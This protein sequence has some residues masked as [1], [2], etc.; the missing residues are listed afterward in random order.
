MELGLKT[1]S[2]MATPLCMFCYLRPKNASLIHGRLGHQV[3][4]TSDSI[5]YMSR[6]ETFFLSCSALVIEIR[7]PRRKPEELP[8]Y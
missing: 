2:S 8:I 3:A 6:L 5:P 4:A 1:V 7:L